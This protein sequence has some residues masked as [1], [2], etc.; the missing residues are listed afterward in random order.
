MISS[1]LCI[2][3]TAWALSGKPQPAAEHDE[4]SVEDRIDDL[5]TIAAEPE[6]AAPAEDAAAALPEVTDP[7]FDQ[8][9]PPAAA[10]DRI[11]VRPST[12][13]APDGSEHESVSRP[14]PMLL[15]G[16]R[17]IR[18]LGPLGITGM[19]VGA[20]GL[21][22]VAVGLVFINKDTTVGPVADGPS[23]VVRDYARPGWFLY[24]TGMGVTAVG[25]IL[26]AIDVTVGR[27]RRL[28]RVAIRPQL[29]RGEAGLQ[30]RGR[31]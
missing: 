13:A 25:A 26:L 12:A 3:G 19:V 30:L 22:E 4:A 27:E 15:D 9:P 24:G 20:A 17:R 14:A 7:V 5:P 18:W 28:R 31:F 1:F 16:R 29:G 21:G 2:A 8:L 6:D 23:I 10:R 11:S